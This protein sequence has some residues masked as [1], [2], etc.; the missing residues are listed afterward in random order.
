MTV[1]AAAI[2]GGGSEGEPGNPGTM[3]ISD[4]MLTSGDIE[5]ETGQ[6][7]LYPL[8]QNKAIAL[9]SGSIDLHM[10]IVDE[11]FKEGVEQGITEVSL[12][13]ELFSKNFICLRRKIAESVHL[14]PLGLTLD[15]FISRHKQL[16]SDVAHQLAT[17]LLNE[18]L[19]LESIVAGVDSNGL[20]HIYSIGDPGTLESHDGIGFYAIGSG[21][22]QFE[23]LFMSERYDRTWP[24]YASMLLMYTAKKRAEVSPGVGG[25][26]D[27]FIL[28]KD[29]LHIVGDEEMQALEDYYQ[30]SL[31]ANIETQNKI[32]ERMTKDP[33]IIGEE[34][35][36]EINKVHPGSG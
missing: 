6:S 27:M 15:T 12:L 19:S 33:R 35:K 25:Q 5:F 34:P 36:T 31:K 18:R 2:Y 30:E 14:A 23:S 28:D 21:A 29:G 3:T 26:T 22:R 20:P 10:K 8:N 17:A 7:K 13:A 11:T 16:N 9:V 24:E 1:C 4:S 32:L